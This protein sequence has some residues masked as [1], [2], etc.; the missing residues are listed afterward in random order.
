MEIEN[1]LK[2]MPF[3]LCLSRDSRFHLQT[4]GAKAKAYDSRWKDQTIQETA[5]VYGSY[6]RV[7]HVW[8]ST[9]RLAEIS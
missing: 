2:S 8:L 7:I 9:K 3:C 5:Y 4:N 6:G 1:R